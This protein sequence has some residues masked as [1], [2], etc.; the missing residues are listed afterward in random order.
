MRRQLQRVSNKLK[1]KGTA[2]ATFVR[3]VLKAPLDLITH[4]TLFRIRVF[5]WALILGEPAYYL[6]WVYVAPQP[7]E[8]LFLRLSAVAMALP[9]LFART[10]RAFSR[11][12]VERYWLLQ[13]FY[14]LPISFFWLYSMNGYNDVW[15]ASSVAMVYLLFQFTDWR[16]ALLQVITAAGIVAVAAAI[17][18]V[19]NYGGAAHP[20]IAHLAI[21]AF[22]TLT[23]VFSAMSAANLR[24]VRLRSSLVTMGV[25]AHDLRTPISSANLIAEAIADEGADTTVFSQAAPRLQRLFRTMNAMIDYQLANARVLDMPTE[26]QVADVGTLV[27]S[28]TLAYPFGSEAVRRGLEVR[29]EK[30]VW[31]S[32]HPQLLRQVV[33]NLLSNAF[34]AVAAT[35]RVFAE[36]DIVIETTLRAGQVSIAVTDKGI[37]IAPERMRTLFQPFQS[38]SDM[39][40]HGLGLTMCRITANA[41]GGSITCRSTPGTGSSFAVCLPARP[42]PESES[43]VSPEAAL[44]R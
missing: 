35:G 4:D 19:P 1:A 32:V 17:G 8:S 43:E 11:G 12:L 38:T 10:H 36:G 9:L 25:L 37:G 41:F 39:P 28:A 29:C 14:T 13:C 22:A 34:R 23:A 26:R 2:A 44:T 6:I 31:C 33:Y 7:A 16:V 15:M 24:L 20:S 42:A 27:K 30:G 21:L 5:C 3:D 40:S 18:L